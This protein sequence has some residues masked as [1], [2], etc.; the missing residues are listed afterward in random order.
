MRQKYC[1]AIQNITIDR[2]DLLY[3][4]TSTE[5]FLTKQTTQIMCEVTSSFIMKCYI[6]WVQCKVFVKVDNMRSREITDIETGNSNNKNEPICRETPR[7]K[8]KPL[9]T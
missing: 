1:L 9:L 8:Q 3:A 6:N 2:K 7:T 4:L 5:V